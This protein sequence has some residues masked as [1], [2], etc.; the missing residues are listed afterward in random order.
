MSLKHYLEDMIPLPMGSVNPNPVSSIPPEGNLVSGP[1]VK[2]RQ[3]QQTVW[4]LYNNDGN[5]FIT[6]NEFLLKNILKQKGIMIIDGLVEYDS[7]NKIISFKVQ[8]IIGSLSMDAFRFIDDLLTHPA[9]V[10]VII[11]PELGRI[12]TVIDPRFDIGGLSEHI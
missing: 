9:I 2:V 6:L 5:S 4:E 10:K 12:S 3:L 7:H 11:E 8:N 1:S